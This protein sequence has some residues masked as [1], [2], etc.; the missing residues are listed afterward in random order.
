MFQSLVVQGEDGLL[1]RKDFCG[2]S[3]NYVRDCKF[4]ILI[5]LSPVI[6]ENTRIN[7]II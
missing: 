3:P 6:D 7:V 2:I 4:S 1:I 5:F